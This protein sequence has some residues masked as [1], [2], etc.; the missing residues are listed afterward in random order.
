VP[1]DTADIPLSKPAQWDTLARYI[2][3]EACLQ[4]QRG[5]L[6]ACNSCRNP[7]FGTVSAKL[8]KDLSTTA[9]QSVQLTADIYNVL[10]MLD[11]RWGQL[12]L[13]IQ[14]PWV[15]PLRLDDYEGSRQRGVYS[16]NPPNL[17]R[18]QNLASR[19]QME[20][21]LRYAF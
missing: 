8:A 4:R 18:S 20:L 11:R 15:R 2:A 7:W 12:Y 17:R 19:W 14:D 5:R 3:R 9:G 10:N 13:A 21:G 16:I 6:L 1:R